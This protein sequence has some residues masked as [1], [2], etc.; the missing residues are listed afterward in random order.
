VRYDGALRGLSV[1]NGISPTRE[2]LNYRVLNLSLSG[3]R[4]SG[5][6]SFKGR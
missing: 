1:D 2:K 4:D 6:M 5:V 3:S